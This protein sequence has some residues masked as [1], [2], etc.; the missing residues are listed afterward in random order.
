MMK[1]LFLSIFFS[2]L[3]S[4]QLLVACDCTPPA[5]NEEALE[6]STFAFVGKCVLLN[7]NWMSGGMK[8]S[9]EV[10]QSWKQEAAPLMILNVPFIQDC[11]GVKFEV[12]KRYLVFV[13]KNFA[14]K[15]NR[16][17]GT[18]LAVEEE[19]QAL[20]EG[21]SPQKSSMAQPLIWTI[22]GLVIACL[23]LIVFV[24]MRKNPSNS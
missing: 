17:M 10:E 15:T 20:G 24:V 22:S 7:T 9:F 2:I 5:S 6:A 18:K 11:G 16:C 13:Q 4:F 3:T 1:R 12:G 14:L 23:A 21:L 8:Y 19:I